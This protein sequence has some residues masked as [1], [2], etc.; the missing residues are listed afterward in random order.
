M[1]A[2]ARASVWLALLGCLAAAAGGAGA[3]GPDRDLPPPPTRHFHDEAGLVGRAEAARLAGL[4]AGF[5]Q[6]TGIQFLIAA[7]PPHAGELADHVNRLYEHWGIGKRGE[8]RG[9]LL[10]VFPQQRE[11]R[12]EVGYGLEEN[13]PDAIANRILDGMYRLPREP[14]SARFLYVMQEVARAVAPE[15]P[16]ARGG[17]P[18]PR[19]QDDDGT[20]LALLLPLLVFLLLAGGRGRSRWLGPLIIASSLGG[21]RRGSGWTGGGLGGGFRGGGGFS[22]GGGAS[23]RW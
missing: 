21:G 22:G 6:R 10:A 1:P 15:D 2:R 13:L 7:L 18:V 20:P 23:G 4:L 16:L 14:A 12:L 5:E 19:G 11:A 9:V 8:D 17:A 3:A